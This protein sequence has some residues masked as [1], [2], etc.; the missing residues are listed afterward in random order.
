MAIRP[1]R[2]QFDYEQGQATLMPAS[3]FNQSYVGP[4]E[5]ILAL[6]PETAT[7]VL[8]LGCSTGTLGQQV[9]QR[10]DAVVVGV[11]LD[12]EMAEVARN[13]L[14]QVHVGDVEQMNLSEVLE[15]GYFDCVVF[16]DVL[17]HLRDP[18]AVLCSAQELLSKDGAVVAS[19]PNVRHYSTIVSLVVGSWPYRERGI[20]DKTHLRFFALK[21]IRE[22][23][24]QAGLQI[25][26]LHRKY[27]ILEHPHMI[28]RYSKYLALGPLREFLTFQYLVTAQKLEANET[29]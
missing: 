3:R 6:V 25:T 14:D 15:I 9:K 23:F 20:H 29:S 21:N 2:A 27:R 11:E 1:E 17:E 28:N 12:S 10:N 16:G 26:Q 18:W 8:D 5:D 13:R 24:A 19:I 22:L 4:R 7:R